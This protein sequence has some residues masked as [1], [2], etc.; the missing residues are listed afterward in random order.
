MSPLVTSNPVSRVENL[1][2]AQA[3]LA[4]FTIRRKVDKAPSG[5]AC[6]FNCACFAV[7]LVILC[8]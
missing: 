5:P 3:F 2:F 4:A 7:L 1:V 6:V 8:L